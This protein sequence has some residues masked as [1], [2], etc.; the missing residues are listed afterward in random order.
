MTTPTWIILG[1][2]SPIGRALARALAARGAALILAGRDTADL[3]ETAADLLIRFQARVATR[4]FDA[5]AVESH[6]AIAEQWAAIPGEINVA[7]VFGSMPEQAAI[8]ADPDLALATIATTYAGAV[9]ILHRLAPRLEAQGSGQVIVFGSVAGDRGRLRNYV[10][11][12]AK[13]GLHAY[14][15]GL[16]ARL[17]RAGCHVLTV[18]PGFIDTAMTWG[19]P[20]V[21]LAAAPEALAE[22][23]L[24]ASA[25]GRNEIYHPWFWRWILLILRHVPEAIFK[26]LSI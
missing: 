4:A 8:D 23:A 9:S 25:R 21:F 6:G 1:A 24:R 14:A 19:R 7:L 5:A 20:G 15:Q 2:S 16:R 18:K 10:Y 26:R 22:A 12:S 11:G 3:A 17:H 13:A